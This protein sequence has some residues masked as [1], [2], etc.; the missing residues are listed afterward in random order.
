MKKFTCVAD[1]GDLSLAVKEALEVKADRFAYT[2]LGRNKTLLMIFSI[3][4]WK[5]KRL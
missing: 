3:F 5:K 1:I 2:E 4:F